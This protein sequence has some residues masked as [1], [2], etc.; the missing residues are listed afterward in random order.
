MPIGSTSVRAGSNS[1]RQTSSVNGGTLAMLNVTPRFVSEPLVGYA[2]ELQQ[3]PPVVRASLKYG[4]RS[5]WVCWAP[6]GDA[7]TT[8]SAATAQRN[9]VRIG[10]LRDVDHAGAT[11]L[12][13]APH[14]NQVAEPLSVRY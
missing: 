12:R 2:A 1:A 14:A 9:L 3:Y 4:V 5:I 11:H 6:T 7:A 10:D 8:T 13:S